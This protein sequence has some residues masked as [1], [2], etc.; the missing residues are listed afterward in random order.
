MSMRQGKWRARAVTRSEKIRGFTRVRAT[1]AL[2]GVT[3]QLGNPEERTTVNCVTISRVIA[4]WYV[5]AMAMSQ[6]EKLIERIRARPPAASFEDV[7]LLLRHFGWIRARE[8]GSH[9]SYRKDDELPIVIARWNGTKV[10]R[11]YLN[12]ICERLGLDD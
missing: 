11:V 12:D 10:R 3:K 2:K 5:W 8:R 6:R 7:D 1:I 4:S 9:V